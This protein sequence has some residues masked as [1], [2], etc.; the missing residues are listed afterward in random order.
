MK[1]ENVIVCDEVRI[2][3]TGKHIIIG[4]YPETIVVPEFPAGLLLC[5]WAQLYLDRDGELDVQ[6]RV[7]E[8][9]KEVSRGS[10]KFRITNHKE[11]LTTTFREIP[12]RVI[13]G[14]VLTFQM[15]EENGKWKTFK[16]IPIRKSTT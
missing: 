12:V 11:V 13:S 10:A 3:D 2:E 6:L 15:R 14:G 7:L 5:I 16:K 9:K 1:F 8:N 4:V